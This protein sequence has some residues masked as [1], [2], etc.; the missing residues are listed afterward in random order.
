[1]EV[2]GQHTHG[3]DLEGHRG[4]GFPPRISKAS[5][6]Q[7]CGQDGSALVCDDGEKE[8]T[9]LEPYPAITWHENK[10]PRTL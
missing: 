10:L 4:L 8:N 7:V 3:L 6:T 1:M 2:I 5:H 9:A